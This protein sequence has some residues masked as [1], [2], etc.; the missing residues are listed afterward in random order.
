MAVATGTVTGAMDGAGCAAAGASPA[1]TITA[2]APEA[3]ASS[4]R[5]FNM[6]E[7]GMI[8][9]MRFLLVADKGIICGMP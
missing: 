1:V 9:A 6:R 2:A 3:V 8:V 7:S 4:A 5:R